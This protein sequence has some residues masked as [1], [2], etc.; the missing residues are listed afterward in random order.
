MG[1]SQHPPPSPPSC[2]QPS[3][4]SALMVSSGTGCVLGLLVVILFC[5]RGQVAVELWRVVALLCLWVPKEGPWCQRIYSWISWPC[6]ALACRVC[7]KHD[8]WPFP[9]FMAC[10][11]VILWSLMAHSLCS[12]YLGEH[13]FMSMV[14]DVS[15]DTL[16]GVLTW[17]HYHHHQGCH[18]CF[19]TTSTKT[20]VLL[21]PW[22]PH[23]QHNH[24]YHYASLA[25]K[26]TSTTITACI[27][28]HQNH[29][30]LSRSLPST[31]LQSPSPQSPPKL[32]VTIMTTIHY[33]Y[34]NHH[35]YHHHHGNHHY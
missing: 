31:S 6:L 33:H 7:K 1:G 29:L 21:P 5:L 13:S 14:L 16:V 10:L 26:T 35:H 28:H 34:Y 19:V 23:H 3:L 2:L 4:F 27:H 22:S 15:D 24:D 17:C 11:L 18:C 20:M 9:L 12:F 32:P 25:T 8:R 30:S